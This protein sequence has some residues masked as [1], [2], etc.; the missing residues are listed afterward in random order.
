MAKVHFPMNPDAGPF[1]AMKMA[2]GLEVS[3]RDWVIVSDIKTEVTCR[4]CLAAMKKGE[5]NA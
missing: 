4:R 2:C 5:D 3:W 1:E